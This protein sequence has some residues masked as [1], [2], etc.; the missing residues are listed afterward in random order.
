MDHDA[1]KMRIVVQDD[2]PYTV[3]GG[4]PLVRKVQIVSEQG[5]PL[6]WKKG[7][8]LE[9][10]EP[11]SLCRCGQSK[12]MPFC[13]GTHYEALFDGT[14]TADTNTTAERRRTYEGGTQIVI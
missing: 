13:D 8:R 2:G 12:N 4:V 10:A 1:S 7:G 3:R 5:E 14:E 9:T 11:Y 6:A